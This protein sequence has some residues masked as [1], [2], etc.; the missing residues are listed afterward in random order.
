[1]A[2]LVM[3]AAWVWADDGLGIETRFIVTAL[4]VIAIAVEEGLKKIAEAQQVKKDV[5]I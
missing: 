5:D 1:M 4:C 3:I 2:W